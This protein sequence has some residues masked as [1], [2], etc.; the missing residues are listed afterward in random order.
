MPLRLSAERQAINYG[1]ASRSSPPD[2]EGAL[3]IVANV[4]LEE[5]AS[6]KVYEFLF[7]GAPPQDRSRTAE[8]PPEQL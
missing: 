8:A 3:A 5:L 1:G 2:T 6:D 4:A 7:V